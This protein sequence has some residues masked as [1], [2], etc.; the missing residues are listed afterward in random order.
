M[1]HRLKRSSQNPTF[2]GLAGRSNNANTATVSAAATNHP[3]GI[4]GGSG[5]GRAGDGRG[6]SPV[7]IKDELDRSVG[8]HDLPEREKSVSDSVYDN[9]S[10]SLFTN[11]RALIEIY[12]ASAAAQIRVVD[13]NKGPKCPIT[14]VGRASEPYLCINN[15]LG[16]YL[17]LSSSAN[18]IALEINTSSS[19]SHCGFLLESVWDFEAAQAQILEYE[20]SVAR[21]TRLSSLRKRKSSQMY[22]P[23]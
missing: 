10:H 16:S 19:S 8:T 7:S 22:V 21:A 6:L 12:R 17:S 15:R 3:T 23:V 20:K 9:D 14:G 18:R 13:V 5:D 4:G 2:L 11:K 1:S